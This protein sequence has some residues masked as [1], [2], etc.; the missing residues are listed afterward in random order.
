MKQ[1]RFAQEIAQLQRQDAILTFNQGESVR[2]LTVVNMIY[3]PAT[4][5]AVGNPGRL[6]MLALT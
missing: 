1:A 5:V 6:E 3:L 2:R 4:F